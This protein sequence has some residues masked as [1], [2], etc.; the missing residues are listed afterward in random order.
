MSDPED[1]GS[2]NGLADLQVDLLP[3]VQIP[4]SNAT[5]EDFEKVNGI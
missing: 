5:K 1:G 3:V 2:E 4:E